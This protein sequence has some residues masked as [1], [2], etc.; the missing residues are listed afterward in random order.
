[1]EPNQSLLV[2]CAWGQWSSY[3]GCTKTCGGGKQYRYRTILTHGEN[4]GTACVG[5]DNVEE[6]ACN[7]ATCTGLYYYSI[8][9]A[10]NTK[11][12]WIYILL[13]QC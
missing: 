12:S 13:R 3:T 2:D 4:D 7:S 11:T 10:L 1:M 6:Q 5:T 8:A 9:T